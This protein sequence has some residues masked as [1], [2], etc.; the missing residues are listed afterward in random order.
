M[1]NVIYVVGKD[2]AHVFSEDIPLER[3]HV[4]SVSTNDTLPLWCLITVGIVL[5]DRKVK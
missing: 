3:N 4:V 5:Y 1:K 2:S